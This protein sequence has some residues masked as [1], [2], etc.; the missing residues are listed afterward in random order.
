L[1]YSIS[2]DPAE[3]GKR[4]RAIG[5]MDRDGGALSVQVLQEFYAEATRPTRRDPL[6]HK[7]AAA[8][9]AAWTRFKVQALTMPILAGAL[10]I[11]AA[12]GLSYWDSAVVAAAAR[13]AAASC[14]ARICR[15]AARWTGSGL[16]IP[17]AE[18]AARGR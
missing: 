13:S 8:L 11:K 6:P 9:V 3:R 1:L 14:S 10:E 15:M 16:S 18:R 5:L 12:H 7:T 17:S 2:G 4:E